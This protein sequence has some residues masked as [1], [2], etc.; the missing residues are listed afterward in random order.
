MFLALLI[1]IRYY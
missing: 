1:R